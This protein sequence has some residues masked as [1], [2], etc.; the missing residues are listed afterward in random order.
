MMSE[1]F[2]FA[3]D[4]AENVVISF[5][6]LHRVYAGRSRYARIDV[7]DTLEYGRALFLDGILQ[8]AALDEFIYHESLVHPAML[9]HPAAWTV[10]VIGGAEGATIREVARYRDVHR[11]VMVDI[12]GE[13]VEVCR[14]YLPEWSAG[15]YDDQRLELHIA[16]GRRYLEEAEETFDVILV[17]LGDPTAESPAV[18]L[19]TREFYDLVLRRL[20]PQGFACFQGED[21]QPNRLA[22]HARMVN[23]LRS[24]FRH[25]A[26]YPYLLP[27]FHGLCGHILASKDLDP[28][29]V[30]LG[31]RLEGQSFRLRYLSPAFLSGLFRLPAY[32]EEAYDR[33][34]EIMSDADP[35]LFRP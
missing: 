4:G 16:D 8:S 5:R 32:V 35:C 28:R 11:I 15:A 14:R 21:L 22:L 3:E 6:A 26:P 31:E 23:T 24:V 20:T 33:Y 7:V 13:L 2:W 18:S 29:T 25:V 1:Q 34:R 19:F 17:D 9:V 12:D 27:S 10:C 30:A